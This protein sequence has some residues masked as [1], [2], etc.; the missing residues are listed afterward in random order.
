MIETCAVSNRVM[1][2]VHEFM[3]MFSLSLRDHNLIWLISN[4]SVLLC[5]VNIV[6]KSCQASGAATATH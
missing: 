5:V 2:F 6:S 3:E 4:F 1:D